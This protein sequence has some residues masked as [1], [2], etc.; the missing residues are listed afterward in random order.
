MDILIWLVIC[1]LATFRLTEM[2]VV[3]DGPFEIFISL[4][5]WFA[6]APDDTKS[7][8]RMISNGLA[9]V[10]CTG[11]WIAFLFTF[12]L[13]VLSITEFMAFWFAIA[14]LQSIFSCKL[15]RAQ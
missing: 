1:S 8:R 15:G 14:G 10:H 13:H 7:I 11:V 3:D 5:G 9:C 6:A 2:L 4:R 12:T